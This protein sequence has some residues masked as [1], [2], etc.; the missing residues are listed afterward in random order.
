MLNFEKLLKSFKNAF[1]GI[2]HV[3][4][5]EQNFRIHAFL[6]VLVFILAFIVKV[7]IGEFITLI[8][9]ISILLVLEIINTA[10]EKVID[11]IKPRVHHYAAEIKDVLAGAG[12]VGA[13]QC[14]I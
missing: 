8:I 4:Q 9:S 12:L 3:F 6:A 1:R 7:R 11:V 14:A 2:Y 10:M 13:I 5:G